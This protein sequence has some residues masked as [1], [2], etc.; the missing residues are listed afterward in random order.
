[1]QGQALG[2]V[3]C[4]L[5]GV[6]LANGIPELF[7]CNKFLVLIHSTLCHS[8][9]SAG[10]C[11]TRVARL[12]VVLAHCYNKCP[13][14]LCPCRVVFDDDGEAVDPLACLCNKFLC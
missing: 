7:Q 5:E 10:W 4:G 11:L 6:M 2:S 8:H 14:S 12:R 1:M 13:Q 9:L 3:L